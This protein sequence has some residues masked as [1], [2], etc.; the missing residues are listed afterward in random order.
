[1]D[2]KH[3]TRCTPLP[4]AQRM[5]RPAPSVVG[6][7]IKA[8][9]TMEFLIDEQLIS[10][11]CDRSTDPDEMRRLL[12]T[13]YLPRWRTGDDPGCIYYSPGSGTAWERNIVVRL[14]DGTQTLT[15]APRAAW[16]AAHS[17]RDNYLVAGQHAIHL[18]HTERREDIRLCC[19]NPAHVVGD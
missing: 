11:L 17:N 3:C 9:G 16:A 12:L 13:D 1:M 7:T 5:A 10:D 2:S 8:R 19:I 15:S 14:V 6:K 4:K 18:C